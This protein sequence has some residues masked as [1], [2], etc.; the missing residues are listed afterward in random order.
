MLNAAYNGQEN[1]IIYTS[2]Q[3]FGFY[4]KINQGQVICPLSRGCALFGG[5][6]IRCFTVFRVCHM[7]LRIGTNLSP[8]IMAYGIMAYGSTPYVGMALKK[9]AATLKV[10][11]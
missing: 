7:G 10:R 5:S 1:V 3:R 9:M 2:S 4:R 11:K 8:I 6:I